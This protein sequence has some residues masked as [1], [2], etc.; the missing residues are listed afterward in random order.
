MILPCHYWAYTLTLA[1]TLGVTAEFD[2]DPESDFM[3]EFGAASAQWIK[4][5]ATD[6]NGKYK[7]TEE[8]VNDPMFGKSEAFKEINAQLAASNAVLYSAQNTAKAADGILELLT[9][10]NPK[11]TIANNLLS[12]VNDGEGMAQASIAYGLY[13]AYA[14]RYKPENAAT[15]PTGVLGALSDPDFQ[16]YLKGETLSDGT[17]TAG[18]VG[19][20][21][22]GYL[23]AMNMI[24][25][26]SNNSDLVKDV[27]V[28]G[29]NTAD[30]NAL[31]NAA[32]SE[33][34]N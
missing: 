28:N 9:G 10:S 29:F 14:E 7:L 27:L 25:A 8:Q 24:N 31:M 3:A 6:P 5:I 33:G 32:K 30:L 11:G 18:A 12:G 4:D 19:T 20:D 34:K 1:E 22:D 13:T 2:M 26:N 21:L 23:A 15:T 17:S 16:A